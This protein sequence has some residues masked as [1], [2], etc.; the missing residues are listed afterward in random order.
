MRHR[1]DVRRIARSELAVKL[2]GGERDF[3]FSA[4]A[5]QRDRD[6]ARQAAGQSTDATSLASASRQRYREV[7]PARCPNVS[8]ASGLASKN[9]ESFVQRLSVPIRYGNLSRCDSGLPVPTAN[10]RY[11][12]LLFDGAVGR[13]QAVGSQPAWTC[14]TSCAEDQNQV[15]RMLEDKDTAFPDGHHIA[16]DCALRAGAV[17]ARS[18]RN[19]TAEQSDEA[20]TA[21]STA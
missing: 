4:T 11:S 2:N 1:R 9:I 5:M 6:P 10:A 8:P 18:A 16:A 14:F 3:C 15:W 7:G 12:N 20:L 19:A 17:K 21:P 13:I